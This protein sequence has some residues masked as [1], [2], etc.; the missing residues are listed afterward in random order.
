MQDNAPFHASKFAKNYLEKK[1]FTGRK[2]MNWPP[3]SP[4]INPIERHWSI[5]KKKLYSEGRQ[6][7]DLESLWRG[8]QEAAKAI[9][10]DEVLALMRSV[11]DRLT[12]V[13]ACKGGHISP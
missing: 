10:S 2:L 5:L 13:L 3:N 9:S 4:D 6:F 8:I 1:G 12:R 7:N 11:D